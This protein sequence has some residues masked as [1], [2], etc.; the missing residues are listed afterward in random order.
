MWTSVERSFKRDSVTLCSPTSSGGRRNAEGGEG[1]GGDGGDG[2]VVWHVGEHSLDDD[3]II[4][5]MIIDYYLIGYLF[6]C[7]TG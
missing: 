4:I 3:L 7:F 1:D 6:L 2:G 5:I